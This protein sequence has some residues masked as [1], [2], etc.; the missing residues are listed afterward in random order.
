M[1]RGIISFVAALAAV[2]ASCLVC[3]RTWAEESDDDSEA[4]ENFPKLASVKAKA[5]SGQAKS[6]TKLGDYY[7]SNSDFTN[8]VLWYRKAADQGEVE[9]QLS[10][11]SCYLTGRGVAKNSQEAA[12]WLRAAATQIGENKA[13]PGGD[14][15]LRLAR[16]NAPV[17]ADRPAPPALSSG[18]PP[19][20]NAPPV[21]ARPHRILTVQA[22]RPE[23]QDIPHRLETYTSGR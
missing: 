22:I 10:L 15:T 4:P 18:A 23:L 17:D 13:G 20:T 6:Q 2:F 21:A 9:A 7:L 16:T 11:A 12:R 14:A 3:A 5:E 8:A 19:R 1:G